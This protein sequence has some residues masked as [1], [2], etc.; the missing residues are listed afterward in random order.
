MLDKSH[1][2]E[3][4]KGC[5]DILEVELMDLFIVGQSCLCGW[6]TLVLKERFALLLGV[7]IGYP[8]IPGLIV[9]IVALR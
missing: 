3:L 6:E 7:G 9:I 4:T 5:A 8:V 2:C 1:P